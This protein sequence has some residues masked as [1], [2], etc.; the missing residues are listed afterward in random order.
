MGTEATPGPG[1]GDRPRLSPCAL[2]NDV[3]FSFCAAP[4]PSL[5]GAV[6]V[7]G[8]RERGL[9]IF[10]GLLFV[11]AW[12]SWGG[13]QARLVPRRT[14]VRLCVSYGLRPAAVRSRRPAPGR[15]PRSPRPSAGTPHAR[16]PAWPVT[17]RVAL[18][19]LPGPVGATRGLMLG[20]RVTLVVCL[21]SQPGSPCASVGWTP[22][23]TA[24]LGAPG[25]QAC[26]TLCVVSVPLAVRVTAAS[27]CCHSHVWSNEE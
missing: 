12:G 24:G 26:A 1:E 25:A 17:S 8:P 10:G 15:E 5:S 19:P 20:G 2:A 18:R 27:E 9:V 3:T 16:S 23:G 6:P 22:L 13:E 21:P 7:P 14:G 4:V 11:T